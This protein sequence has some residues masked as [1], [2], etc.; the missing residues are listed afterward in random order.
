MDKQAVPAML[1]VNP[2]A[3]GGQGEKIL[4]R[5]VE[6][7]KA[8]GLQFDC[9]LTQSPGHA[10]RLAQAA[11]EVGCQRIIVC[12]GDGTINEVVN[13][14]QERPVSLGI[15]PC[16]RGNDLARYLGIPTDL[17]AACYTSAQGRLKKLDVAQIGQR[18]YCSIASVGLA[19][20]VNRL[21]NKNSYIRKGKSA[22]LRALWQMLPGFKAYELRVEHDG[23]VYEGRVLL[24]AV[25]N[26]SS[27]GGGLQVT[28]E[29]LADDGLLDICIVEMVSR[30]RFLGSF[31]AVFSGTH[32][33]YGFVKYMRSARVRIT[34]ATPLDVFADGE[35]IQQ[36]PVSILVHF[37]ALRFVVP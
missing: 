35:F 16:G 15:I 6:L 17:E 19:A 27:F 3:G 10:S 23:G 30:L 13:G 22:Y 1:L 32:L 21:A 31:P 18:Y 12:G 24:V 5:V 25:G 34:A 8:Q 26:S 28:P 2:V 20:D 9:Q 14:L 36:L 7:L 33:R 29:A 11:A 37:Q 4:G